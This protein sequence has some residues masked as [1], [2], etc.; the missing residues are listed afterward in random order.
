MI[1][2]SGIGPLTIDGILPWVSAL[3][4][5]LMVCAAVGALKSSDCTSASNHVRA[6]P[7]NA[8]LGATPVRYQI[9]LASVNVTAGSRPRSR[10]MT[11]R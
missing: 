9:E 7:R 10:S 8:G 1:A 5:S 2:A 6:A 11:P 3:T 4:Q